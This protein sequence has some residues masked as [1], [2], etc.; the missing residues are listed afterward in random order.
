MSLFDNAPHRLLF[1]NLAILL[2]LT[3]SAAVQIAGVVTDAE[4][5][6]TAG[7]RGRILAG[8]RDETA[9]TR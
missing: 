1:R 9:A 6:T 3:R 8:K 4:A 5:A 2:C 7:P